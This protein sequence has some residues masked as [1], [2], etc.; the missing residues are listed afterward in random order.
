MAIRVEVWEMVP[1]FPAGNENGTCRLLDVMTSV[2]RRASLR[3]LLASGLRWIIDKIYVLS[4]IQFT[5]IRRNEKAKASAR[6]A[7]QALTKKNVALYLG[8][9][10]EI[11]QRASMV[12]C[13]ALC[14]RSAF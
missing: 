2:L 5:N 3:H 12:L 7:K 4:P 14:H 9:K 11:Q 13:K 6:A 1:C 8:M 10:E